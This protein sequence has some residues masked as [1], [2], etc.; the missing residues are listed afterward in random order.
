MIGRWAVLA[1]TAA[2]AGCAGMGDGTLSQQPLI[3]APE[4]REEALSIADDYAERGRWAAALAVLDRAIASAPE[5]ATLRVAQENM[6]ARWADEKRL[7]ED[8]ILISDAENQLEKIALLEKLSRAAPNN[9]VLASRRLYW[10]EILRGKAEL[11]TQCAER[12]VKRQ[13][14]LAKRCYLIATEVV[15][16]D[17]LGQRLAAVSRYLKESEQLAE[18]RRRQRAARERKARARV[19][20]DQ[21]KAAIDADDYRRALDRLQQVADLQPDNPEVEALQ[22]T[23]WSMISPQI[24]ALVKL[25]DHLYLNEQLDSAVATW[26]AALTL[27]PGDE[28]IVARIE[29]AR[30]VLERLDSLRQRQRPAGVAP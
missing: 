9:L 28:A 30:T 13:P 21:A 1:L 29:R 3:K 23:A 15:E 7:L 22:Q 16:T 12:Y 18:Q 8:Q 20:L 24:N 25:G 5:D 4:S 2:I 27:K 11:L 14:T 17:D 26:Q 19:L 6:T 10:K